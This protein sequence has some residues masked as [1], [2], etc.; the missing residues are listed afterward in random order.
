MPDPLTLPTYIDCTIKSA[1]YHRPVQ[2]VSSKPSYASLLLSCPKPLCLWW[3]RSYI[4]R[5]PLDAGLHIPHAD[6]SCR[7]AR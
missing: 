1:R 5:F 4:K 3:A 6:Q 7:G 2:G